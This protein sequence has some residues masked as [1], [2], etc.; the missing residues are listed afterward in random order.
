MFETQ[1][2]SSFERGWYAD[3]GGPLSITLM[4]NS[5]GASAGYLVGWFISGIKRCR[6]KSL[7]TNIEVDVA[8]T[9]PEFDTASRFAQV[10]NTVFC[11]VTYSAG[12]PLANV[13]AVMYFVITYWVDRIVLLRASKKPPSLTAVQ[14]HATMR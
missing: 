5:F 2:Y 9:N 10:L 7:A 14:A 8:F 12:L 11:T 13:F 6:Y 3:V 4:V 1:P